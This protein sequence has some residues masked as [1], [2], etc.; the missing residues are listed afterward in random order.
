MTLA[1]A[2][3]VLL[4]A[5]ESCHIHRDHVCQRE[6]SHRYCECPGAPYHAFSALELA[7]LASGEELHARL[8]RKRMAYQ[9]ACRAWPTRVVVTVAPDAAPETLEAIGQVA[10]L[11]V[12]ALEEGTLP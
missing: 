3:L 12:Q 9:A 1:R 4:D 10:A 6:E 7:P 11:V 5:G 8:A 2:C